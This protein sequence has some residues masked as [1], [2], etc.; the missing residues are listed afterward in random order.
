VTQRETIQELRAPTAQVRAMI[1]RA[2]EAFTEFAGD[3]AQVAAR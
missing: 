2:W 1:P 3:T